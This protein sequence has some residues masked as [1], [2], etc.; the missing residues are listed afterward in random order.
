[1]N[2]IN[3]KLNIF[4]FVV[5][6]FSAGLFAE[7]ASAQLYGCQY[8]PLL[9]ANGQYSNGGN[10]GNNNNNGNNSGDEVSTLSATNIDE[11]SATLRGEVTDGN[12]V[13]VW[14]VIDDNDSTP[15]CS[16]SSIRYNVSGDYDEGDD[17]SRNV[18]GLDEDETY[19]FRA[20]TNDDSGN[21]RSF[22]TDDDNNY[23]NNDDDNDDNYSYDI[24]ALS[25][26]ATGVTTNS[27]TLNG[28]SM[29]N[30][31]GSGRAWFQ[32]GITT[33][34][35]IETPKQTVGNGTNNVSR[36]ISGLSSRTPYYYRMVV[37][38]NS[39]TAYGEIRTFTTGGF[40]TSTGAGSSNSGSTAGNTSS[41]NSNNS[42]QTIT[43]TSY[44]GIDIESNL[45]KVAVGDIVTFTVSYKN[46]SGKD[47]ERVVMKVSLPAEMSFRKTTAGEY[48]KSIHSVIVTFDKL[49]KDAKGEFIVIAEVLKSASSQNILVASLEAVHSHPVI[50]GAIVDSINYSILEVENGGSNLAAGTIFA[51]KF[52]PTSFLGWL[53]IALTILVII[54][55]AR[56]IAKDKE[57]RAEKEQEI[58]IAR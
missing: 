6:L 3:K 47:L 53:L 14:F 35:G 39:G 51:G 28:V 13:D 4:V 48:S 22:T 52:F 7:K 45:D 44:L 19:Y 24:A 11:D 21:V 31:G 32:F 27:A 15:S 29:I 40:T 55:I 16:D 2:N 10:N 26:G 54:L 46:V 42:N 12:N 1:M 5:V 41:N 8:Y 18:S 20:C 37:E 57:E 33:A 34:L 30:E 9:C 43:S 56:K 38:N 49:S 25:T 23:N 17:F 50:D 58:K 36:Q